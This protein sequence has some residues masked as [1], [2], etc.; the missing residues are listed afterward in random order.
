MG[1]MEVLTLLLVVFAALSYIDQHKKNQHPY[2][3]KVY[4]SSFYIILNASLRA[5]RNLRPI[6]F[7]IRLYTG[8]FEKSSTSFT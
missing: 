5:N 4:A 1:I 7:L 6:H 8:V 3:E 2:P